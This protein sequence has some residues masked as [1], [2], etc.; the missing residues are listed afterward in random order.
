MTEETT[1]PEPTAQAEQP[2]P[3]RPTATTAST[4]A[5]PSCKHIGLV[6]L[7]SGRS[8]GGKPIVYCLKCNE[9]FPRP[10]YPAGTE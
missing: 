9:R 2:T 5:C 3:P 6:G 8:Y 4:Y 10:E 7:T 1:A